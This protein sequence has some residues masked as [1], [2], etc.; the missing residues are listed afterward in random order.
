MQSKRHQLKYRLIHLTLCWT[1]VYCAWMFQ[2]VAG[3]SFTH[4]RRR[5]LCVP[6]FFLCCKYTVLFKF[7]CT[8]CRQMAC[9]WV[10]Y[11]D[12]VV[13]TSTRNPSCWPRKCCACMVLGRRSGMLEYFISEF[14]ETVTLRDDASRPRAHVRTHRHCLAVTDEH[15]YPVYTIQPVVKPVVTGWTNSHCSFNRLS[16]RVVQPV[17]QPVG[18][19]FTRYSRLSNWLYNRLYNR[20]DNRLNKQPLFV[21]PVIKPGCTTGSTTGCIHDRA[22]Y[23]TGNQ[24]GL[25]TGWMFVYTIQP[26]VKPVWQ[27]VDNRLYRVNGA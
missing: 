24:T 3:Y 7:K 23:Q 10:V 9:L 1:A 27:P 17:S 15:L 14:T 8:A 18:C 20:F 22:G 13:P 4:A 25:T 11:T 2:V 16:N 12:I 19:L 21:Q 6:F 5:L 26:V